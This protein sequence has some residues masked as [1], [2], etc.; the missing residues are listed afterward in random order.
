MQSPGRPG[1]L[2]DRLLRTMVPL[3]KP[4]AILD[5]EASWSLS[6]D[7]RRSPWV[8]MFTTAASSDPSRTITRY[9]LGLGHRNIAF[10]SP[11]HEHTWSRRR[12]EG[13]ASVCAAAGNAGGAA[14]Y[15]VESDVRAVVRTSSIQAAYR[16][17]RKTLEAP[18]QIDFDAWM[19]D[20]KE[21]TAKKA[22]IRARL[23]PLLEQALADR[24]HTAATAWVAVNDLTALMILEFLAERKVKVP[25]D[26][27][28]ISFDDSVDALRLNLTSYNFNASGMATAMLGYILRRKPFDRARVGRASQVEGYIVERHTTGPA[29]GRAWAR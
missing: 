21:A 14:A 20:M 27:S 8:R 12:L 25:G 10:I 22:L 5:E 7:L 16:T 13:V 23:Y 26:L 11:F 24:A 3:K 15:T 17:F 28:V 18:R 4:L 19:L 9:L 29:P 6:P 2:E 1:N